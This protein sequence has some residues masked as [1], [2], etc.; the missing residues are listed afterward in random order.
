MKIRSKAT[1]PLRASM[2]RGSGFGAGPNKRPPCHL[3]PRR[4]CLPFSDTPE[5]GAKKQRLLF[6]NLRFPCFFQPFGCGLHDNKLLLIHRIEHNINVLTAT[7]PAP[8]IFLVEKLVY[9]NI[10][11]GNELK[12]QIKTGVLPLVLIVRSV[13]P[14]NSAT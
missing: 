2:A 3:W 8:L 12:E 7:F 6:L 13:F 10:K 4:N 9:G 14:T 1:L 11:H 5:N